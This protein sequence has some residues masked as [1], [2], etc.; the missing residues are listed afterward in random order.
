MVQCSRELPGQV[1]HAGMRSDLIEL[2]KPI[3]DDDPGL[4][5]VV[6]PFHRRTFIPK[7]SVEALVDPFSA[8]DR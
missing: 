8:P 2:T 1:I 4:L 3:L 7:F 5:A 6:E